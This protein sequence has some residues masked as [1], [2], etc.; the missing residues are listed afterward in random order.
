VTQ[1]AGKLAGKRAG[2]RRAARPPARRRGKL[3][4]LALGTTLCVVAWGYL[5]F[6]AI[7]FGRTARGGQSES[8]IFLAIASLGAIACL[9]TGLLLV[10]RLLKVL[11]IVADGSALDRL[12]GGRR[13]KR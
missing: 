5:V 6:A 7:D 9:F 10:V 3:L 13:A 2:A 11:G 1:G 12:P 4:L 8:W